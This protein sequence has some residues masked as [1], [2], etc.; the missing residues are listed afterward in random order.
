MIAHWGEVKVEEH[1]VVLCAFAARE[2]EIS[3]ELLANARMDDVVNGGNSGKWMDEHFIAAVASGL[4]WFGHVL[5]D[6]LCNFTNTSIRV[7]MPMSPGT[8]KD[9]YVDIRIGDRK[10]IGGDNAIVAFF[11]NAARNHFDVACEQG[12]N[13]EKWRPLAE[14]QGDQVRTRCCGFSVH[15]TSTLL[16]LLLIK[17]V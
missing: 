8:R 14:R 11:G 4:V 3:K 12:N 13:G 10:P 7:Y 1:S 15:A 17:C 16:I 9:G 5:L 2:L 6:V